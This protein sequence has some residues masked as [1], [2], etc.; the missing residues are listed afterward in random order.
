MTS[1]SVPV[2]LIFSKT[3]GYRHDSISTAVSAIMDMFITKDLFN[4]AASEDASLFTPSALSHYNIIILLH[5]SGDFLT[6]DQLG[7]LQEY[8]HSGGSVLAIHGAA[9]GMPSSSWYKDLIGAHFDMHPDPKPGAILVSNASHPIIGTQTPPKTWMDEWYNF[10]SHPS[11]NRNLNILL[12]GDTTSFQGGKHGDDHPLGWCQEF[13]G[14]M[15]VYLALGHFGQAYED[16][17]FMGLVERGSLWAARREANI[18]I[19]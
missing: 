12:R 10:K 15:S 16:D 18:D 11:D 14:G 4:T 9:A 7:A 5:T 8:M 1:S 3:A 2:A 19:S 17:W 13:E 6:S